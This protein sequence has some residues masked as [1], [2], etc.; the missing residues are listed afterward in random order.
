MDFQTNIFQQFGE[1]WALVTAGD[2]EDFNTMT[3][4]WG[5]LGTI[6]NKPVATVYVRTVRYTHEFMDKS[7]YFTVSFYP[8]EYKKI[9]GVLG[10]RSGREMDKKNNSGLTPRFLADSVTFEEAEVTLLCRKLFRQRIDPENIPSDIQATFYEG[11]A[12]HDMYIGEVVEI[13]Q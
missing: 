8:S 7:E 10:A 11:D 6:W 3:V 5:G 4:S 13:I 2:K 1:K 12:P 9:L